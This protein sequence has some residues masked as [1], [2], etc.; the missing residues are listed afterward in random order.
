MNDNYVFF[1][2]K[3]KRRELM[4][5]WI[6]ICVQSSYIKILSTQGH[7]LRLKSRVLRSGPYCCMI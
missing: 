4:E 7:T 1:P 5:E 2:Q 6:H 3:M